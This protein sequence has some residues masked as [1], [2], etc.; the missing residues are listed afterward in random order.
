MALR[1]P[2]AK[3]ATYT[4]S[5]VLCVAAAGRTCVA[6]GLPSTPDWFTI[7][8]LVGGSNT[9]SIMPNAIWV[10]SWNATSLVL[11]SSV[12]GS[13]ARVSLTAQVVH[14]IST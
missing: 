8:P 6:H 10:E 3:I 5:G 13:T 1:D 7:T 4:Y 2:A 9:A 11:V 14:S 12:T